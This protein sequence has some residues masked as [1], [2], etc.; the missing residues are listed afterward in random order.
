MFCQ[1]AFGVRN[2]AFVYVFVSK[3]SFISRHPFC[4]LI[5]HHDILTSTTYEYK[6][7]KYEHSCLLYK[8]PVTDSY[9]L[10]SEKSAKSIK[11]RFKQKRWYV[12]FRNKRG[13]GEDGGGGF[14]K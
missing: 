14:Y 9:S 6:S 13:C 5:C 3:C 2:R 4:E 10:L 1:F 7:S 11:N 8:T 12:T